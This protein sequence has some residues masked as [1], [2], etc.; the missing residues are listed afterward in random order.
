MRMQLKYFEFLAAIHLRHHCLP[1]R[2]T[3]FANPRD[4]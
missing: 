4:G 3:Y 1:M 2:L